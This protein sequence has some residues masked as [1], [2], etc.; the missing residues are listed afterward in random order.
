MNLSRRLSVQHNPFFQ[1]DEMLCREREEALINYT[2]YDGITQS[3]FPEL[4]LLSR[5]QSGES[6]KS[7]SFT[8]RLIPCNWRIFFCNT[9][10]ASFNDSKNSM[11][12]LHSLVAI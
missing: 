11:S 12:F 3:S 5:L 7:T 6:E 10:R 4:K 9:L 2:F 1:H 8:F